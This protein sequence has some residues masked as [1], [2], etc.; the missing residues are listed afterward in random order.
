[1]KNLVFPIL[2][3]NIPPFG[4]EIKELYVNFPY[5]FMD[6]FVVPPRKDGEQSIRLCERSEAIQK[7]FIRLCVIQ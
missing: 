3:N 6:C 4:S 1:M 7:I 5:K 2:Q